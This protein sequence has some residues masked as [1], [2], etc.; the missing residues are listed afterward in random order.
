MVNYTS[1]KTDWQHLY[2]AS[3]AL[4]KAIYIISRRSNTRVHIHTFEDEK[5]PHPH[6]EKEKKETRNQHSTG[7]GSHCLHLIVINSNPFYTENLPYPCIEALPHFFCTEPSSAAVRCLS[8][9]VYWHYSKRGVTNM[10]CNATT[11]AFSVMYQSRNRKR[12][13]Q[14]K[15][16]SSKL[17]VGLRRLCR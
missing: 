5:L 4:V 14:D 13:H 7:E 3:Q 10:M 8:V 12:F 2:G 15:E 17:R 6:E 9:A 16:N 1:S 11:S